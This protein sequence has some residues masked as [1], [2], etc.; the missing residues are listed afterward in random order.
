M[1][2]LFLA[3]PE[4]VIYN[5]TVYSVTVPGTMGYM[6]ILTHHAPIISLLKEGKVEVVDKDKKVF[7]WNISGGFL[8]VSNNEAK[9][10]ADELKE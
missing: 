10:L 2:R 1:Y 4:K 9:L 3:T 6:E 8:E 7:V 5:D